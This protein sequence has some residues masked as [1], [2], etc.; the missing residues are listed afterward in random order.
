MKETYELEMGYIEIDAYFSKMGVDSV[1]ELVIKRFNNREKNQSYYNFINWQKNERQILVA[2]FRVPQQLLI[3]QLLDCTF[4]I[5]N[6]DE[7]V[8][9]EYKIIHSLVNGW[10]PA[11]EIEQG[12]NHLF[13]LEFFEE[14]PN[15][16]LKLYEENQYSPT[17]HI[18]GN[19]LG[20]C[21][22][23]E[24]SSISTKIKKYITERDK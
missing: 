11:E 15:I 14:I 19:R 24:F 13:V 1:K 16:F 23:N 9:K 4:N 18:K 22:R 5:D 12:R 21:L 10:I 2:T 8:I 17:A 20:L 7:S 6:P 3:H